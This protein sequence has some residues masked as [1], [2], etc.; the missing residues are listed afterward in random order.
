METLFKPH[1]REASEAEKIAF[2]LAVAQR[3][4][5]EVWLLTGLPDVIWG[6]TVWRLKQEDQDW[7][8]ALFAEPEV[9]APIP[10]E[11]DNVIKL[12]EVVLI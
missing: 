4:G 8:M 9:E 10:D 3:D 7:L 2:L 1:V 6:S 11:Q 12:P 5:A